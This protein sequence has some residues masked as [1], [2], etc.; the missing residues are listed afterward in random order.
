MYDMHVHTKYSFDSKETFEAYIDYARKEGVNAVC[1]TEHF[2][3]N[4]HDKSAGFYNPE[5]FFKEFNRLRNEVTDIRLL[6][7]IEVDC[8]HLYRKELSFA[9]NFPYDCII[10]S[11]HYCSLAEDM[12][13]SRLKECGM[14]AK[15]C[16]SSYWE[17]LLS[18]VTAGGF[19]VVGHFDLPKRY[20][21][22]LMYEKSILV[23]IFREMQKH[24][25]IP[26]INTSSL[27]RGVKSSLPDYEILYLY[28]SNG[29]EYVTV[30]SDA[31]S[32][33]LLAADYT[34]A[35]AIINKLGL[36]QVIFVNRKIIVVD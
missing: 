20:Y 29:G 26:E 28:K 7:G 5:A 18:C 12:L 13:F 19:D 36:Q 6:A 32:A 35:K 24:N 15:E 25:I 34:H 17:E 4:P 27:K 23:E 33:D 31:H 8:P 16:F 3:N 11:V 10:G 30:G 14:S 21:N 9:K 22:E 2:D 1:F